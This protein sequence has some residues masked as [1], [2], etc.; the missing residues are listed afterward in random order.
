M[1]VTTLEE[2]GTQAV[3]DSKP[4]H[5][6][7][8]ERKRFPGDETTPQTISSALG[9]TREESRLWN[10]YLR[11]PD[12]YSLLV[13]HR[14][15][16]TIMPGQRNMVLAR[17]QSRG[18]F[19]FFRTREPIISGTAHLIEFL[20]DIPNR[21]VEQKK[22]WKRQL[23]EFIQTG[24]FTPDRTFE[25]GFDTGIDLDGLPRGGK[26]NGKAGQGSRTVMR[27]NGKPLPPPRMPSYHPGAD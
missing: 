5:Q 18:S 23:L 13:D 26:V 24:K 1:T 12:P 3:Q 27:Q 2:E 15:H 14:T 6:E 11:G 20:C 21:D 22:V 10:F 25:Q 4:Q 8:E 7:A 16:T 19:R 17:I 9:M